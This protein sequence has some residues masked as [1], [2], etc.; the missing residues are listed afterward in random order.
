MADIGQL[1]QV[2]LNLSVNAGDAIS[3]K[4]RIVIETRPV[5]LEKSDREMIRDLEPGEYVMISVSDTGC[6]MSEEVQAH[7]F[8]PFYTTKGKSGTGLGLS[9]V[10]GIVKQHG[11]AITFYSEPGI[12]TTFKVYLP[13]PLRSP[14]KE[15][16][17]TSGDCAATRQSSRGGR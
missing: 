12:G 10:Y 13:A 2:I 3:E 6:G 17:G 8:E 9:S 11:G 15:K 16:R 1:E 4:G 14:G 5:R 7:V